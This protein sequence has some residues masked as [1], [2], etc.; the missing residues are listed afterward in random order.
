[1]RPAALDP[2]RLAVRGVL[3][4]RAVRECMGCLQP[5][6][7]ISRSSATCKHWMNR[8]VKVLARIFTLYWRLMVCSADLSTLFRNIHVGYCVQHAHATL[9]T[10]H[11]GFARPASRTCSNTLFRFTLH[12]R[13]DH[14]HHIHD[15]SLAPRPASSPGEDQ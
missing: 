10:A 5:R 1:M 4:G 8:G 12:D 7:V 14:A 15:F 6:E 13:A 11:R 2:A 3:V 9:T